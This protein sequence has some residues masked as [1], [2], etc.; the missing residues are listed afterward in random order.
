M[1][2]FIVESANKPGELARIASAIAQRGINLYVFSLGLGPRGGSAFLATDEAGVKNALT[3]AG[4]EYRE[5]PVLAISL[6]DQPGTAAATAQK[7]ADAGV[8]IELFAPVQSSEGKVT[9]VLG[10]DK[11]EDAQKLL[12]DQ[13]IEW[14]VPGQMGVGVSPM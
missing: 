4:I 11:I 12:A 14:K 1:Q 3:G 6:E 7:L 5:I 13:F 9:I 10:V 8:N 2:A